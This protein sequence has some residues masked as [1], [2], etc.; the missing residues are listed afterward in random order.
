M[1]ALWLLLWQYKN[2]TT[3]IVFENKIK[4]QKSIENNVA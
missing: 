3:K 1:T 4:K 2:N